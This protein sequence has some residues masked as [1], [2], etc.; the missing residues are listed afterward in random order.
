MPSALV[1]SRS[2]FTSMLKVSI[3]PY[4]AMKRIGRIQQLAQI[5]VEICSLYSSFHGDFVLHTCVFAIVC[6]QYILIRRLGLPATLNAW[7]IRILQ[8]MHP[9]LALKKIGITPVVKLHFVCLI[10]LWRLNFVIFTMSLWIGKV[11]QKVAKFPKVIV[12]IKDF[13]GGHAIDCNTLHTPNLFYEKK[14]HLA[15]HID[16][17]LRCTTPL[18]LLAVRGWGPTQRH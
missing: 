13:C 17:K 15:S 16:T 12:G 2:A 5:V 3:V 8:A 10:Y 14:C 6:A 18:V 1:V 11:V 9:F 7:E 4:K